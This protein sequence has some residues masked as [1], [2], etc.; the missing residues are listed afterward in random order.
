MMD[1]TNVEVRDLL[2]EYAAGRLGAAEHERVERHLTGCAECADELSLIRAAARALGAA[3]AVDV[4]RIVAALPAPARSTTPG[5][6]PIE[7]RRRA[8]AANRPAWSATRRVAAIAA[9]AVGAIGLAIASGDRATR[10][11]GDTPLA[12]PAVVVTTPIVAE[13]EATSGLP[14]PVAQVAAVSGELSLASGVAELS[15]ESLRALMGDLEQL[16][17]STLTEPGDVL[18]TMTG[19]DD[20]AG[21]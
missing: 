21:V 17:D 14:A 5:I 10:R 2:P 18:P 15:D 19:V 9:V 7:S 3:P 4:A 20:E 11:V 12:D 8:P 6:V 16:D 1:C 13:S